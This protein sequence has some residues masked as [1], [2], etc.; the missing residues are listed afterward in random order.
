[1]TGQS[2]YVMICQRLLGPES[3]PGASCQLRL[4]G[5]FLTVNFLPFAQCRLPAA[6]PVLDGSPLSLVPAAGCRLPGRFLSVPPLSFTGCRLPARLAQLGPAWPGPAWPII[7]PPCLPPTPHPSTHL[8]PAILSPCYPRGPYGNPCGPMGQYQIPWC[9]QGSKYRPESEPLAR[10]TALNILLNRKK[11]LCKEL[12][13]ETQP[14]R[15]QQSTRLS[16]CARTYV[17][18]CVY[19]LISRG[20]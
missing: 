3:L 18:A 6:R 1:M 20:V 12:F 15:K 8:R 2:R 7:P 10:K 5:R 4:L 9:N 14:Q 11:Q 17:S 19:V 16:V 13:H